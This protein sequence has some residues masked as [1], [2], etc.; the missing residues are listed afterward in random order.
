LLGQNPGKRIG[1]QHGDHRDQARHLQRVYHGAVVTWVGEKL[2]VVRN[3]HAA[4][5]LKIQ[6]QQ[7]HGHKWHHEEK[8]RPEE[9]WSHQHPWQGTVNFRELVHNLCLL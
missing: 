3:R 6:T 2:A 7:G 8:K 4:G 9:R 5:G 1:E